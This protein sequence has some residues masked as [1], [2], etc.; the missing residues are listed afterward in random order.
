MATIPLPA[1]HDR[2]ARAVRRRERQFGKT[3]KAIEARNDTAREVG[4]LLVG[5]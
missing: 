4:H 1:D 2:D 3:V 5:E